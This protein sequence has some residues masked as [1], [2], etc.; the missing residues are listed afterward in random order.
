[1]NIA[2]F[3]SGSGSNAQNI[4]EYFKGSTTVKIVRIYS[5]KPDAYVLERAKNLGFPTM[6][7][8]S[9]ELKESTHVLQQ[10]TDDKTDYIILAGFL[11]MIPR[12]LVEVFEGRIINI[13]PALLPKYGGKGMYGM[14]V[15]NAV[16]AS[17]EK[18]TG[19]TIHLV[20][21]HYDEGDIIFQAKVEIAPSD[22]PDEIANKVHQLE[23]EHF[24]RVIEEVVG[25]GEVFSASKS[26][27]VFNPVR[28][29]N[30]I[31]S[32]SPTTSHS[33]LKIQPDRFYHIYNR[34]INSTNIFN[35]DENKR[36]FL[37]KVNKYLPGVCDILAYCFMSNHY[38]FVVKVKSANELMKFY[39]EK[40]GVKAEKKRENEVKLHEPEYIFSKQFSQL[41]NSY[42][43]AFNK[44]NK[45]HGSLIESPFK[46]LEIN[47]DE[48][49]KTV[50]SYVH[51]NPQSHGFTR[52]FRNWE[53]SSYKKII[54]DNGTETPREMVLEIFGGLENFV[55]YHE[56]DFELPW[57]EE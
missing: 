28:L 49:L 26:D 42:T 51:K 50:I 37:T 12:Y 35:N 30:R 36:Y 17:G 48:Y 23:Y 32:P 38:H 54:G 7:F 11:L 15:H 44:Q 8:S 47:T 2:I 27:R 24:P 39:E 55:L 16:K 1:M 31:T 20:N 18:E 9:Y 5:N 56:R 52:D 4:V 14:N 34:G 13:H 21:E 22:S 46:R 29:V 25:E 10:L 57:L 3:A 33:T 19:I 6:V 43:Q 53:F 40:F 41:F 45:R